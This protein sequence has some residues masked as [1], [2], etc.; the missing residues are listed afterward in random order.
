MT[1][2]YKFAVSETTLHAR[3]DLSRASKSQKGLYRAS[4]QNCIV[5]DVR[6]GRICVEEA[7]IFLNSV[8]CYGAKGKALLK[9]MR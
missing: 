8:G 9:D 7:A 2:T 6:S 3:D 4:L 1:N 5:H